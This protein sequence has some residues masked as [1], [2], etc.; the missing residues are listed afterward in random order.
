MFVFGCCDV[1][2]YFCIFRYLP[3]DRYLPK[4]SV[5]VRMQYALECDRI[6]DS[7]PIASHC[8][9]CTSVCTSSG[10]NADATALEKL[11]A[12]LLGLSPADLARLV[13]L[14]QEAK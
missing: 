9:V 12:A 8:P 5:Y 3:D 2:V 10:Q 11:A 6:A 1:D 7:E 13:A 14:L 4:S